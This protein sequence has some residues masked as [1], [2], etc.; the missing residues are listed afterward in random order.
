MFSRFRK[1]SCPLQLYGKLPIA[2]DYLRI[3]AGGGAGRELRDWLDQ[4]FSSTAERG[5]APEFPWPLR[6]LVSLDGSEPLMGCGWSSS[7]AGG[8]RRFP[9]VAFI[10]RRRRA[11]LS[12]F[13]A[14]LAE[15]RE[16]WTNI[17]SRHD[18]FQAFSEGRALLDGMRGVE[19]E[20]TTDGETQTERIDLSNW[21]SALWPAEGQEGLVDTLAR[22]Q[23]LAKE[24][25][26]GPI[27]LPL[28]S[29]LSHAAQVHAWWSAMTEIKL[30]PP[31]QL[32]TLF[33]PLPGPLGDEP[34]FATFLR[35][36]LRP[37]DVA[38]ISSA[39]GS[40]RLG[41]GDLCGGDV[42]RAGEVQPVSENAPTLAD[43]MRGAL[44]SARSRA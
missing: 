14:G 13:S 25:H 21:T 11:L 5:N 36:P 8:H 10:E 32:P 28:V 35:G 44:V 33:F 22:L 26:Q 29:D 3:G 19:I 18:T 16:T 42:R 2:K 12:E 40:T 24:R 37:P 20:I 6:F 1:E 27:R 41:T 7:D 31:G 43:S 23:R 30:L 38:W 17:E 15:C 39:R 9:F 4:G 34:A